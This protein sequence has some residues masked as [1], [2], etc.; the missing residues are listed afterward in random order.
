[1]SLQTF[2][3][4]LVISKVV[5]ATYQGYKG[6]PRGSDENIL[7][8][9]ACENYGYWYDYG[10]KDLG[11]TKTDMA[12][13]VREGKRIHVH[14]RKNNMRMFNL[15]TPEHLIPLIKTD[16]ILKDLASHGI[17]EPPFA[18]PKKK[19]EF[20]KL[21][22]DNLAIANNVIATVAASIAANKRGA[23]VIESPSR[24]VPTAIENAFIEAVNTNPEHPIYVKDVAKAVAKDA[25][26]EVVEEPVVT[27]ETTTVD[28]SVDT[29]VATSVK[30]NGYISVYAA[31]DTE[32]WVAVKGMPNY[33]CTRSGKVRSTR[34]LVTDSSGRDFVRGGKVLVQTSRN[35]FVQTVSLASDGDSRKK[36]SYKVVDLVAT[37]FMDNLP[38]NFVIRMKDGDNTNLDIS[39]YVVETESEK[40][41]VT[42]TP[43]KVSSVPSSAP[44]SVTIPV[45]SSR[46]FVDVEVVSVTNGTTFSIN[47]P[48]EYVRVMCSSAEVIDMTV[49]EYLTRAIKRTL[50]GLCN[51]N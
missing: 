40:P 41:E 17:K 19:E 42:R 11:L 31:V 15:L 50:K 43:D 9:S 49:E 5:H 28:T 46:V 45:T 35:M 8:K 20:E 48:Q 25:P 26:K 51:M 14:L 10:K 13:M 37:T 24:V 47:L 23:S 29:P 16:A 4:N 32:E 22:E 2:V 36:R 34:H 21:S 27:S 1:M 7:Y 12:P 38:E 3:P 18:D 33:E 30:T 39:N 6:Y 44:S